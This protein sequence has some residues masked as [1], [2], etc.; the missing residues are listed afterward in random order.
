MN[1]RQTLLATLKEWIVRSYTVDEL[2][3]HLGW[4]VARIG[5]AAKQLQSE[6]VPV[7]YMFDDDG[8]GSEGILT[9]VRLTRVP[10]SS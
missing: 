3:R 4:S 7:V 5:T 6:G 8:G 2:A 9:D 1:D 10:A